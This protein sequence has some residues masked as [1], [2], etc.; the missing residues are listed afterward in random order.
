MGT[1]PLK[2]IRKCD[3]PVVR[4][5]QYK[6]LLEHILRS[7]TPQDHRLG[8]SLRDLVDHHKRRFQSYDGLRFAL[9][10]RNAIDHAQGNVTATDAVAAA[11][12]LDRAIVDLLKYCSNAMQDSLMGYP[13]YCVEKTWIES[14]SSIAQL[15]L[16]EDNYLRCGYLVTRK[17]SLVLEISELFDPILE[18][19]EFE[20]FCV[21]EEL[22]RGF[23][24]TEYIWQPG[25]RIKAVAR[26]FYG[27]D[28]EWRQILKTNGIGKVSDIKS[29]TVL[30]LICVPVKRLERERRRFERLFLK[31][32]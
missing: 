10:I 25:D 9:R 20:A 29:F 27:D 5:R 14:F 19:E 13:S 12:V 2:E 1:L 28:R 3:H 8:W 17:A 4:V 30:K 31:A 21:Q 11:R 32:L 18:A 24:R 22:D 7:I 23:G 26:R 16:A 6:T 15:D